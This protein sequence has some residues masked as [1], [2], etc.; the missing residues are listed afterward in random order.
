MAGQADKDRIVLRSPIQGGNEIFRE[1]HQYHRN[2]RNFRHSIAPTSP[3][4]N[5]PRPSNCD[6]STRRDICH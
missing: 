5:Q 2:V 6:V 4:V 1:N 3:I